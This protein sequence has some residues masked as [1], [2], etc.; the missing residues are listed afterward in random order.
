LPWV[1]AMK[2]REGQATAYLCRDF[3]C[4]APTVSPD[5]LDRLLLG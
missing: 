4:Q 5:D 3:V 2:E 1:A